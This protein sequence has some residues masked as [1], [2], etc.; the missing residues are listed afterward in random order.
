MLIRFV[1]FVFL[2]GQYA[3][4]AALLYGAWLT[5]GEGL[6]QVLSSSLGTT[7]SCRAHLRLARA[8]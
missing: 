1:D 7:G 3:S 8:A 2:L 4:V 6:C 5:H